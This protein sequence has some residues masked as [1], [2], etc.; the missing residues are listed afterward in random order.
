M[1]NYSQKRVI[2]SEGIEAHMQFMFD[3]FC[4][5]THITTSFSVA[6]NH[7]LCFLD[8][9]N[10]TT[11]PKSATPETPISRNGVLEK[12]RCQPLDKAD[13]VGRDVGKRHHIEVLNAPRNMR[14]IKTLN[15]CRAL[16]DRFFFIGHI[17]TRC[18]IIII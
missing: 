4:N 6:C 2:D 5:Q 13:N 18:S 3:T 15:G 17:P 1:G 7:T 10:R 11:I 12:A 9:I 8:V 14:I 16:S